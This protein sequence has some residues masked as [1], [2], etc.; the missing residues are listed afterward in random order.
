MRKH[1]YERNRD[2]AAFVHGR[3][4]TITATGARTTPWVGCTG[5]RKRIPYGYYQSSRILNYVVARIRVRRNTDIKRCNPWRARYWQGIR[6]RGFHTDRPTLRILFGRDGNVTSRNFYI[7]V[8]VRGTTRISSSRYGTAGTWF[9][10]HFSTPIDLELMPTRMT[11][12]QTTA[13]QSFETV[14]PKPS[15]RGNLPFRD[16]SKRIP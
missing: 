15:R 8:I 10:S 11:T 5:N 7:P 1:L 4:L 12:P 2:C 6:I 3:L 16:P 13:Y 14:V 9:D